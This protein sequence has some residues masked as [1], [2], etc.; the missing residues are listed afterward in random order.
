MCCT[1]KEVV[2]H[3]FDDDIG[4]TNRMIVVFGIVRWK[5]CVYRRKKREELTVFERK[6]GYQKEK[7][8]ILYLL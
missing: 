4:I 7:I 8:G 3:C 1:S 2:C 6:M 5:L